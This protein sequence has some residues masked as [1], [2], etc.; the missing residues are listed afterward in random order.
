MY[1]NWLWVVN[2]FWTWKFLKILGPKHPFQGSS[3]R[4]VS[5]RIG[6]HP[7]NEKAKLPGNKVYTI[8]TRWWYFPEWKVLG[9][10]M[11]GRPLRQ[12]VQFTAGQRAPA[13]MSAK[14][15]RQNWWV[16]GCAGAQLCQRL[17]EFICDNYIVNP[18]I[19]LNEEIINSREQNIIGERKEIII[20]YMDLLCIMF[21]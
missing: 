5:L 16:S 10:L 15:K 17:G 12:P 13:G 21:P 11:C 18:T 3:W 7:R 19:G 14:K 8:E 2:T 4:G 6:H 20:Y 9:Q 1:S